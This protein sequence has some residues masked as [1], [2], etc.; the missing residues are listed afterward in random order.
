LDSETYRHAR[1][2]VTENRRCLDFAEALDR[3]DLG[4]LG[5]LMKASHMSLKNDYQ[6]SSPALDS[7]AAAAWESEGCIGARM[8][9]A[10]FGGACVALVD[11]ERL[12]L[13][14]TSCLASY[15]VRT[16]KTGEA[17]VCSA[18]DGA[19]VLESDLS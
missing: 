4:L 5:G 6:V 8:T 3:G 14:M 15:A 10:G 11:V 1:H 9:G 12:D 16:G 17:M 13:F 19:K 2:V 18:S 7:M